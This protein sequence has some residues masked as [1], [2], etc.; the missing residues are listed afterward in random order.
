MNRRRFAQ[1]VAVSA[2]SYQRILGA[3]D[4][5]GVALIGAGRRGREVAGAFLETGK[6]DLRAVCD[7]YDVQ[8]NVTIEKLAKTG[9]KPFQCAAHQ[10]ALARP[11]VD[12]VIIA[13]PD[14]L[15]FDLALDAFKAGKHVYLEKPAT[16]QFE[17]GAPLL[18]AAR[19]SGKVCQAGLQ[20]RSG[21][22]YIRAKEDVVARGLLGSVIF[23]RSAWSNFPWQTRRIP[24][25]PKPAGL[26]WLRFLGRAPYEEYAAVRYD[27]WRYFPE[28]GG[29]VLADIMNHWVDVAQWFMSATAPQNAVASG[30][31]YQCCDGRVNPDTVNAILQYRGGWNFTFESTVHPVRDDRPSV[32]FLG[33]EGQLD[34]ARDGYVFRPNKG[35]PVNVP[36]KGNL[37]VAHVEDFLAAIKTG[38][39]PNADIDIGL[40]GALACHL[41]RAAYWSRKRARYDADLQRILTD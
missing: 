15:H 24:A 20:Q 16:H 22:H 21:E 32:V 10:D 31:V 14:H 38:K 29:G 12:A 6:S 18:R 5:L 19:L 7:V 30:G 4:R 3:N 9:E 33:T 40:Q 36:A 41:A 17:E 37:D 13:T 39:K 8:R 23:I 25:T 35:A 34:I 26:D 28:Y 1:T 27:S 2:A 11:D